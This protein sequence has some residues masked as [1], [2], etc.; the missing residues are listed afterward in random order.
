[1]DGDQITARFCQEKVGHDCMAVRAWYKACEPQV[2]E[3]A[4]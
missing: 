4:S 1:M 3:A 2:L